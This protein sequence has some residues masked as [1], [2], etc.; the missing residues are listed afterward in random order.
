MVLWMPS[1][2]SFFEMPSI[3]NL[4]SQ[5]FGEEQLYVKIVSHFDI[6]QYNPDPEQLDRAVSFTR[7]DGPAKHVYTT[8]FECG[9]NNNNQ[10]AEPSGTDR[11]A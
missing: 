10:T 4:A 5:M 1:F 9:M 11:V 6:L 7:R 3:M 8:Q 2:I